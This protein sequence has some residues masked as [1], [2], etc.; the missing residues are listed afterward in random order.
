MGD[1][2]E[3][4]EGS[5]KGAGIPQDDEL[6]EIE[7]GAGDGNHNGDEDEDDDDMMIMQRNNKT[8]TTAARQ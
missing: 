3:D 6:M 7:E 1:D 8:Q 5:V 4:E 2:V